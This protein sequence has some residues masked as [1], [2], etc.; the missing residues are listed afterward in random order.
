MYEMKAL[1]AATPKTTGPLMEAVVT[2][3]LL[4]VPLGVV[5]VSVVVKPWQTTADP[6]IGLGSGLTVIGLVTVQPAGVV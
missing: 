1:P 6:P 2:S 4:Q 5:S 3:L